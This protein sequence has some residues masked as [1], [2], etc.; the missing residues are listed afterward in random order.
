[1]VA[2]EQHYAPGTYPSLP[3]PMR[4]TGPIGWVRQNLL[5]S[6][7]NVLLTLL[8]VAVLVYI[9]PS[10]LNWAIF[11]A[12]WHGVTRAPCNTPEGVDKPGACWTMVNARFGQFMY[13]RYPADQVWRVD[14]SFILLFASFFALLIDRVPGKKWF[15]IF[16]FLIYPVIGFAL[17][18]GGIFGLPVVETAKWG[19]LMLTLIIATVSILASVP[20]GIFLALGR[21]SNLPVIRVLSITFIEFVRAVPLI[22]VLFMSSVMLPLFLPVGVNFDKLLRAL[23]GFSL[24]YAAYMAEVVRGG[25]Q[26]MPRGQYEGAMALGLGYWKMMGLVILPQALRIVIPGMVNNFISAFKDTSL[27]LVIGLFDLLNI[28]TQATRDAQWRGLSKEGYLFAAVAYF[29][30][31]FAMSRYSIYLER[32]LHTGYRR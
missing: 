13:G 19:G 17:F 30:F 11:D 12:T 32:K 27:V 9:L 29:I 10:F 24:F 4:T 16:L 7:S 21:R 5:S 14:L 18:Y 2:D 15:A 23:V 20:L 8:S 31:C 22:T 6:P 28:V 1:M 25:L 3:P 26:A